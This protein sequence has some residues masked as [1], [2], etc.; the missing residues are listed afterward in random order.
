MKRSH[1]TLTPF[2]LARD[3]SDQSEQVIIRWTNSL[4]VF[5]APQEK[6]RTIIRDL[7]LKLVKF[8]FKSTGD[9]YQIYP[10][11]GD[12]GDNGV[13]RQKLR[14]KSAF[15]KNME[16]FEIRVEQFKKLPGMGG[17]ETNGLT[18]GTQ[19]FQIL[20]WVYWPQIHIA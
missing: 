5:F 17:G 14:Y 7:Y 18:E 19:S 11:F 16:E 4:Q 8:K 2:T 13:R 15:Q 20:W 1:I 10:D 12:K 3:S 6:T 9:L